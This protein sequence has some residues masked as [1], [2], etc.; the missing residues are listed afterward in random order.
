MARS[1]RVKDKRKYGNLYPRR[2]QD[3]PFV[4]NLRSGILHRKNCYWG[5][6]ILDLYQTDFIGITDARKL[7]SEGVKY[8]DKTLGG[9]HNEE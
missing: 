1:K 9:I 8:A 7:A 4:A 3:S 5:Q 2:L 6:M